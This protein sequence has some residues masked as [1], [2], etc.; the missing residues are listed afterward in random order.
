MSYICGYPPTTK[1]DGSIIRYGRLRTPSELSSIP[2]C[3]GPF[4]SEKRIVAD[5][6][7]GCVSGSLRSFAVRLKRYPPDTRFLGRRHLPSWCEEYNFL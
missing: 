6:C 1:R 7:S 3:H 2:S 4:L 5:K